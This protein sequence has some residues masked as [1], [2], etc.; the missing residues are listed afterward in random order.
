MATLERTYTIPLHGETLKTVN[1]KRTKK[2]MKATREFLIKHMKSEDV[3]LGAS[4]NH[5]IWKHGLQNP[6]HRIKVTAVKTD[7][8]VVRV[9]LFGYK[10]PAK[11]EMGKKVAKAKK[12]AAPTPKAPAAKPA[13]Q[14]P[15]AEAKPAAKKPAVKA[16]SK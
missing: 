7:D 12:E 16:E 8:N 11:K 13:E 4:V 15:A 2:A 9:E 10:A 6:P 3:R 5:F 14:K 1:W